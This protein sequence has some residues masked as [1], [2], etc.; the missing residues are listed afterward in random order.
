MARAQATGRAWMGGAV[1][2]TARLVLR[3]LLGLA[4]V[5]GLAAFLVAAAGLPSAAQWRWIA[6][7]GNLAAAL[8]ALVAAAASILLRGLRWTFLLPA[9][10]GIGR[11]RLVAG[12]GWS[13]LV[14][15]ALPFRSGEVYRPLWLRLRGGSATHAAASVVVERLVDLLA[16]GGLLVAVLFALPMLRG[17]V[18]SGTPILA[19]AAA[20]LVIAGCVALARSAGRLRLPGGDGRLARLAQEAVAGLGAI[21]ESRRAAAVLALTALA[22]MVLAAGFALYLSATLG[23]PWPVGVAVLVASNLSAV[24]PLAP[25]NFGVFEAAAV[26][27]LAVA[28]VSADLALVAAIGLHLAVIAAIAATGLACRLALLVREGR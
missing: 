26:A 11:L 23:M 18:G 12:F 28:G 6:S 9:Q 19:M 7:G 21:G 8:G 1:P 22:W 13:F 10:P 17:L 24:V 3:T 4:L 5:A 25:G 14:L 2:L 15:Q 20:A 16:L 27:V